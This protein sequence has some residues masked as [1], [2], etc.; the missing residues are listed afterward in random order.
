MIV[1]DAVKKN[2]RWTTAYPHERTPVAVERHGLHLWNDGQGH[3]RH[4]AVWMPVFAGKRRKPFGIE[5][6]DM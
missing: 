3:G 2:D 1:P 5:N 6:R 4:Y